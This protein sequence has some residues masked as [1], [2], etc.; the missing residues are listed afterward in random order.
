MKKTD[1]PIFYDETFPIYIRR[2][3]SSITNPDSYTSAMHEAVEIKY[4]YEGESTILVGNNAIYAK[5]GDIVFISPYEFHA[6]VDVGATQGKY[7][8]FMV[9]LGFFDGALAN[10][11]S[12]KSLLL[13]K[14]IKT[15][16]IKDKKLANVLNSA[17]LEFANDTKGKKL[18]VFGF[19]AEFFS[20]LINEDA[21]SDSGNDSETARRYASIEP[22]VRLMRDRYR[23]DLDLNSLAESC[24]MSKYHF[25]RVFKLTKGESPMQYLK[26]YRL[27]IADVLIRQGNYS[28]KEAAY[29][30][31]FSDVSYF[32]RLY[33]NRFSDSDK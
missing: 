13:G 28:I 19:L 17:Y 14:K 21:F 1:E 29:L 30:S 18:A 26:N 22:A 6:T 24:N 3:D 25:T 15:P 5:A 20:A 33:K 10:N 32:S 27:S 2:S 12:L 31:G 4:F 16:L 8:L 9:G 7:I 11:F 23:E